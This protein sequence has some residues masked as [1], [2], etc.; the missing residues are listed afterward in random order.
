MTNK[1]IGGRGKKAPYETTHVRIPVD[2]KPQIELLIEKFRSDG[3]IVLDKSDIVLEEK[4]NKQTINDDLVKYS[5][6]LEFVIEEF[7]ANGLYVGEDNK[8]KYQT[9]LCF[10]EDESYDLAK[11]CL[12][13]FRTKK[14]VVR[15]L[16]SGLYGTAV[17]D[18]RL[19]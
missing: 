10:G 8:R 6:L 9:T 1:Q 18:P 4:D 15:N 19:D 16:L 13:T 11:K 12:S 17:D 5:K 14:D 3:N 7:K 2:L